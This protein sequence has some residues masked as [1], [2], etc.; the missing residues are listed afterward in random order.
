MPAPKLDI[1]SINVDSSSL[2]STARYCAIKLYS[3][4][5]RDGSGKLKKIWALPLPKG[6]V[7]IHDHDY[8]PLEVGGLGQLTTSAIGALTGNAT[9]YEQNVSD[10]LIAAGLAAGSA[11]GADGVISSGLLATRQAK[12]PYTQLVYK[13]PALRQFQFTWNLMPISKKEAMQISEM[14]MEI[15]KEIYPAA[16]GVLFKYPAEFQIIM[17]SMGRILLQTTAAACTSFQVTY[18]TQGNPYT[19]TDGYP[20]TTNITMSLQ[21]VKLLSGESIE[22]LYGGRS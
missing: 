15:R 9:T 20:V 14:V 13:S 8:S 2:Q 4:G 5:N 6:A 21:E 17:K 19:H 10:S 18:D 22:K 12:N 3:E 16:A 1:I 11:V 7:D